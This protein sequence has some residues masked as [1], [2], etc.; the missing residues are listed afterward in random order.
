M[1]LTKKRDYWDYQQNPNDGSQNVPCAIQKEL[2]W[3]TADG[4][5]EEQACATLVPSQGKGFP[6]KNANNQNGLRMT[7][8]DQDMLFEL[9]KPL[10][11][12]SVGR[13]IHEGIIWAGGPWVSFYD[14]M[15]FFLI[16]TE[17]QFRFSR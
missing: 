11:E 15:T 12:N 6:R 13:A 8:R 7:A 9:P 17:W 1:N 5:Y 14:N 2:W 16:A 3:V 4:G 10:F